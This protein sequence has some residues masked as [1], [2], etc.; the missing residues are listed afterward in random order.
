MQ[1]QSDGIELDQINICID[2]QI[3]LT[4]SISTE[5]I[6]WITSNEIISDENIFEISFDTPGMYTIE[7][8]NKTQCNCSIPDT[9]T[10]NVLSGTT[11]GID[12]VGTI[13][14]DSEVTYY[15]DQECD[16]YLW[17]VSSHGTITDGGGA[18]DYFVTVLWSSGSLG[19]LTLS[20]PGCNATACRE[21]IT[22]YIPIIDGT[23]EIAGP[24]TACYGSYQTYSIPDFQGSDISWYVDFSDGRI[25][26][27]KFTN[28]VVV[29]WADGGSPLKTISV[30]YDNCNLECSGMSELDV[31]L[32]DNIYIES[33]KSVYCEEAII[34]LS[35]TKN[36]I[37]DWIITFPDLSTQTIT[38]QSVL[39]TTLNQI[40]TYKIVLNDISGLSCNLRDSTVLKITPPPNIPDD[41]LGPSSICKGELVTYRV[42]N[43][44]I[45][46]NVYWQIYDGDL[47]T[48]T[49]SSTSKSLNYAWATDGPYQITAS[50]EDA[51]TG[52]RGEGLTIGLVDNLSLIGNETICIYNI[53][54][55]ELENYN[56][57][58]IVWSIIPSTAGEIISTNENTAEIVFHEYGVHT[59][60]AIHCN[61]EK[62]ISVEIPYETFSVNWD[63]PCF[64]E[65]AE[66]NV[67]LPIGGTYKVLD[68]LR[69]IIEFSD[70][71]R[72]YKGEYVIQV[73][74][75]N[76]CV[77]LDTI[78]ITELD[79]RF[80]DLNISPGNYCPGDPPLTLTAT[81][82]GPGTTYRW[83]N[84]GVVFATTTIP[85]TQYSDSGSYFVEAID[86]H[87]CRY[88]D[89]VI[90]GSC[91]GTS[92]PLPP[93]DKNLTK[94]DCFDFDF[95]LFPP[96]QSTNF[97]WDFDDPQSGSNTATGTYVSHTFSRVGC[98]NVTAIGD[99]TE[100]RLICGIPIEVAEESIFLVCI[101]AIP[102]FKR[103]KKCVTDSNLRYDWDFGDTLS[104]LPNTSTET[105]PEHLYIQDGTYTVT[106]TAINNGSCQTTV[107]K[108]IT[109]ITPSYSGDIISDTNYPKC[110]ENSAT[111]SAPSGSTYLWSTEETTENIIV[112]S[113]G[114]YI[115]TTTYSD[116]CTSISPPHY[117]YDF[118]LG[119]AVIRSIKHTLE[120]GESTY[121]YDT[122]TVCRGEAFDLE[123]SNLVNVS[124]NWTP[125][126]GSTQT[127]KYNPHFN[128]LPAGTYIYDV[129]VIHNILNCYAL[130]DPFVVEII[131]LPTQP[132]IVSSDTILC[133]ENFV[134]LSI[135]NPDEE[136][137]YLWSTGQTG[138]EIS[139]VSSGIY[140]V[141]AT[142]SNGCNRESDNIIVYN[143][144]TIRSWISGCHEVCFPDT[145]CMRLNTFSQYNL[146]KNETEVTIIPN[147]STELIIT[148]PGDYQLQY[149]ASSG[150][151]SISEILT[152]DARPESHMLSGM[153]YL[154]EN[155]NG[156]FDGLDMLL[157]NIPVRVEQGIHYQVI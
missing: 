146:I 138:T 79:D 116:G 24:T 60:Q 99:Y 118:E 94:N 86:S 147:T 1:I 98:F 70:T 104:P 46:Q 145:L 3:S 133:E 91:C 19:E 8:Q 9:I 151:E 67:T 72:V 110:P 21:S 22:E 123:V 112:N 7:L 97:E 117:V 36:Q 41:I 18:D 33:D 88:L 136:V 135:S 27:G 125:G 81:N 89:A 29:Q 152:L 148:E 63:P 34:S 43:I 58:E 144:P 132:I 30:T 25:K 134:T 20:T 113:P 57:G 50:I 16:T 32:V 68:S 149:I 4:S 127:L 48:P 59:I 14:S 5:A 65:T 12:C 13:C 74:T 108:E 38:N 119:N 31:T 73:T 106:L 153:V 83:R 130:L 2:E 75:S 124:Y 131:D 128:T 95:E 156:I 39:N 55:Y 62:T 51:L 64:G 154:D 122:L 102:Y 140:S 49:S 47:L 103:E 37:V 93:V 87:G 115:V 150:C 44:G 100:E 143:N 85:T 105:N 54:H 90:V 129:E 6:E 157:E 40:G 114:T 11:P 120:V 137:T 78:V 28:E 53:G 126:S 111:L 107:T 80:F 69:S 76:E 61:F 82:L 142:N 84:K 26:S 101:G 139:G 141:T 23:A 71:A 96:Y 15:S 35:N 121:Q 92:T 52:C 17:S 45:Y 56:S 77:L 155:E 109:I 66:L 10:V 42:E